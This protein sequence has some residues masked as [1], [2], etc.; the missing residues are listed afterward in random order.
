MIKEK[1]SSL[2]SE[3][4]RLVRAVGSVCHSAFYPCPDD[5]QFQLRKN[6]AHLDKGLAH[7]IDLP[8]PAID[9]DAADDDETEV[10]ALHQLDDLTELLGAPA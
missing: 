5:G 10:F 9:G 4:P 6:G 1:A 7:G 3:R 2:S 8:V